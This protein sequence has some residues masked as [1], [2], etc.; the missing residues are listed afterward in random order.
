MFQTILVILNP[1]TMMNLENLFMCRCMQYRSIANAGINIWS[2][3]LLVSTWRKWSQAD[4]KLSYHSAKSG[5]RRWCKST[6]LYNI[7][8]GN[9]WQI[10]STTIYTWNG[11]LQQFQDSGT[12]KIL[13]ICEM[14]REN[15]Q[16]TLLCD[17]GQHLT[18]SVVQRCMLHFGS[19]KTMLCS[20]SRKIKST[21]RS[22]RLTLW[23][24]CKQIYRINA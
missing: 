19:G 9:W 10:H 4:G 22:T 13:C 15:I 17:N 23:L 7:W 3:S 5:H 18:Q 24:I 14:E 2:N 20:G 6:H 1:S 12:W 11:E 8:L 16:A 21:S